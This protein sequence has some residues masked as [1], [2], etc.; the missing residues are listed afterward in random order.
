MEEQRINSID[1]GVSA[2]GRGLLRQRDADK[3]GHRDAYLQV[4]RLWLPYTAHGK[5]LVEHGDSEPELYVQCQH[6]QP[7]K[8][9]GQPEEQERELHV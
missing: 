9:H 5:E 3:D 1:G 8:A 7:D 2:H 4:Q 6:R